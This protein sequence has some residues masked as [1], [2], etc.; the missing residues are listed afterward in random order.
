MR[1]RH[2]LVLSLS[3]VFIQA[4]SPALKADEIKWQTDLKQAA[5]QARAQEKAMLI[6]IGASWCGFCHKMDKETFQDQKVIHHINSCFIPLRVDADKSPEFVEAIGVAGLPTTVII[7]PE[8]KIV[9]KLSGY[10][11]AREM[12]GHL[13]KICLVNHEQAAPAATRTAAIKKM[14]QKEV[15]PEFA[16]KN[17]CLVSMLDDQELVEGNP[18]YISEF[19]GRKLCFASREHKQKFDANPMHY[20]PAF[21]GQCRVSQLERNQTVEGD[22]YAGGVYRERLVFFTS[23]AERERFSSNPSYYLAQ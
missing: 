19:K 15:E 21:D 3:F 20:W 11:A 18:K 9:K 10:V 17:V 6:Q 13:K 23:E 2:F 12:Q 4:L 5:L 1:A 22:P 16:F 7:T 14:S 8:L